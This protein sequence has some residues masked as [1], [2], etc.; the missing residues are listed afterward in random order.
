MTAADLRAHANVVES[1][2]GDWGLPAAAIP[3][4]E[5]LG[6]HVRF[7]RMA[8]RMSYRQAADQIGIS[9]STMWSIESGRQVG[10]M[11]TVL[12]ILRWIVDGEDW[13]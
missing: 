1:G 6:N 2:W 12:R 3:V 10:N 11:V 9:Y 8:R 5:H 7:T 4:L 13:A